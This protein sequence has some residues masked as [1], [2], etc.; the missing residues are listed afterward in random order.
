LTA[1]CPV[2]TQSEHER[3]KIAAAQTTPWTRFV[4]RKFLM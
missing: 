1:S 4:G 2:S 3:L